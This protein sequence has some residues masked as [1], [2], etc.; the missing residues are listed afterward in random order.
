MILTRYTNFP[1][2]HRKYFDIRQQKGTEKKRILSN[3]NALGLLTLSQ[4]TNFTLFQT[5]RVC[6][7]QFQIR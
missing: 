7:R 2:G 4:M 1:N 3:G 6:R 5:E